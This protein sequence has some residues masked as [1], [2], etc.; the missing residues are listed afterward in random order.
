MPPPGLE[1]GRLAAKDFK[2]H[3]ST[4]SAIGAIV[5]FLFLTNSF[6]TSSNVG[7]NSA[8]GPTTVKKFI[9]KF[10]L[11]PFQKSVKIRSPLVG[12]HNH[13]KHLTPFTILLRSCGVAMKLL[14]NTFPRVAT[15]LGIRPPSGKSV[16]GISSAAKREI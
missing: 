12:V 8:H 6:P 4:N 3:A 16:N 14:H 7:V 10:P 15:P 11:M 13:N 1:P 5:Y 2:S 9:C